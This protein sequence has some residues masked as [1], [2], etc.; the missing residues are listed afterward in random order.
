MGCKIGI[1]RINGVIIVVWGG[2]RKSNLNE[3][4]NS[5]LVIMG[6][7]ARSQLAQVEH[8]SYEPKSRV[9]SPY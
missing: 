7:G 6:L 4:N 9:Q 3:Q 2:A 1:R 8:R 5:I